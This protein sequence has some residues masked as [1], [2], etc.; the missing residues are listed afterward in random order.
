MRIRY[1]LDFN[2]LKNETD[3]CEFDCPEIFYA[4]FYGNQEKS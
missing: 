3:K 1:D 4:Q 2:L